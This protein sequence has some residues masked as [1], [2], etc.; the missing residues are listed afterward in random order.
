MHTIHEKIPP[1][2]IYITDYKYIMEVAIRY[3]YD[4]QKEVINFL[5]EKWN[6]YAPDGPFQPVFYSDRISKK[7]RD[8]KDFG[9]NL[10]IFSLIAIFTACLGLFGFSLF[11]VRQKFKEIGIR[12]V[13]GASSWSINKLLIKQFI[14]L[15]IIAN[16]FSQPISYLIMKKWL[17]NFAYKSTFDPIIIIACFL[18]TCIIVILTIYLNVVR[19]AARNPVDTLK[20]E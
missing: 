20:Y 11:V 1:I 19:T 17:N 2:L 15:A 4:K 12:K 3:H 13:L 10:F 6:K 9:R 14:I 8:E 5:E 16:I 7:Y 18:I